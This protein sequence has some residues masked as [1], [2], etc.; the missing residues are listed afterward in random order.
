MTKVHI[1][2]ERTVDFKFLMISSTM[3]RALRLST[4]YLLLGMLA[5]MV[6][7]GE[8]V[9]A[10]DVCDCSDP[11]NIDC[12]D[13]D[14]EEVPTNFPQEAQAIILS[15]NRISRVPLTAF[16]DLSDLLFIYMRDNP[17]Y[18]DCNLRWLA[19]WFQTTAGRDILKD[20]PQCL[21]PGNLNGQSL[22]SVSVQDMICPTTAAPPVTEAP[23]EAPA[24]P[25]LNTWCPEEESVLFTWPRTF[26][27]TT[28]RVACP[29]GG[30]TA[31]RQCAWGSPDEGA[32]WS[33]P[34]VTACFS[35]RVTQRL[36]ELAYLPPDRVLD[37][38]D[39]L[40]TWTSWAEQFTL[41]DTALAAK[42]LATLS[43]T[44]T[45]DTQQCST[46][47]RCISNLMQADEQQLM[48]AQRMYNSVSKLMS[49]I[50]PV[51]FNTVFDGDTF[52]TT[53]GDIA[54]GL[55][56][57]QTVQFPGAAFVQ[58]ST[59]GRRS[60][61]S[62]QE[63]EIFLN[64]NVSDGDLLGFSSIKLPTTLL[65]RVILSEHPTVQFTFYRSGKMFDLVSQ[66]DGNSSFSM[67]KLQVPIISATVGGMHVSNLYDPVQVN[68]RRLITTGTPVC[69]FWDTSINDWSREGC[70]LASDQNDIITCECNHLT[71]FAVLMD[72]YGNID[73]IS[74]ADL[75]ALMII[76]YVGCAISML[77]IA[78]TLLTYSLFRKLRRDNPTKILMNLCLALLLA[79][80]FFVCSGPAHNSGSRGACVTVA[81][82]LHYFLLTSMAWMGLEALNLYLAIMKVFN[83]YYR[84]FMLKFCIAG[85]GSPAVIVAITLAVNVENYTQYGGI[86]WLQ[87]N[88]FYGAFLTPVCLVLILNCVMFGLVIRQLVG[89]AANEFKKADKV[90]TTTKLRGA[91][92]LVI[93]LGLTWVLAIFA[94][95]EASLTFSYLFAIVN[96]LQGMFIFVFHCVLKKDVQN[97]WKTI[98]PCGPKGRP[99]T[100]SAWTGSKSMSTPSQLHRSSRVSDINIK[101]FHAMTIEDADQID[102]FNSIGQG[103]S[104]N[105][106]DVSESGSRPTT[107]SG[108][109]LDT[110][111]RNIDF[112]AYSHPPITDYCN[113]PSPIPEASRECSDESTS[114][115]DIE[116]IND[117]SEA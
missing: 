26:I 90:E 41:I 55:G 76:S 78:A 16:R 5:V 9:D 117:I 8:A 77:G 52:V 31:I 44:P 18:C 57:F 99:G 111:F 95:A 6:R 12:Q 2:E 29:E 93:L 114:V 53:A 68:F 110:S 20:D 63:F 33:V 47:L 56:A 115:Y 97:H 10:C 106:D 65:D 17:F 70:Q 36:S 105:A 11:T 87:P 13:R 101:A 46:T 74:D 48:E 102:D 89:G 96:S 103:G 43:A 30:G 104:D 49:V 24:T 67:M 108:I 92:G 45:L 35:D 14:L 64:A 116:T 23:T 32:S 34:N 61:Q 94:I 3:P 69:V 109:R 27:D 80:L 54:I 38:I 79:I 113:P 51:T 22:T 60:Y 7:R 58:Q 75:T 28:A 107:A 50:E 81:V 59:D 39:E 100:P 21:S 82:F 37:N 62:D 84:H 91:I 42:T 25:A 112:Q 4:V 85:W 19:V 88:A 73:N 1:R 40:Q 15:N 71:N 86:C 83:T 98:L 72:I 66:A